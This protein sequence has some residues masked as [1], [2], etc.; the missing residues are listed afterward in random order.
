MDHSK[1]SFRIPLSIVVKI[2]YVNAN[3]QCSYR[4]KMA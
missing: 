2:T 3:F 4:R 1:L